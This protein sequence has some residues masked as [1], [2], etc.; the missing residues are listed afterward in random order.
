[1]FKLPPLEGRCVPE[2]AT[3]IVFFSCD[4]DYFDRHGYALQQSINRTVGWVHVHCHIINEG[5]M[6][7]HVLDDLQSKYK[8]TYTHES[9]TKDFYA[10]LDKNKKRMK[11]GIHI[12]KT[13]DLDYIARRTY[14]ASVRF[15]RLNQ[16]FKNPHQHIFQIDCDTILRNGFHTADFRQLTK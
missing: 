14:L 4:Y 8:F 15:M 12:F 7:K 3:D 2:E 11:E 6:D 13:N 1:M 10:N 9:V 5:N 16:L